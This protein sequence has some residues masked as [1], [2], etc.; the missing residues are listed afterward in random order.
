LFLAV[1][2]RVNDRIEPTLREAATSHPD[3]PLAEPRLT[4]RQAAR[5]TPC[6]VVVTSTR[7]TVGVRGWPT[8]AVVVSRTSR[9]EDD[10]L[11]RLAGQLEGDEAM[12]R[13]SA[14]SMRRE[15]DVQALTEST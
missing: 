11:A 12:D 8:S 15:R 1:L 4:R 9:L 10:S 14:D 3:D 2:G 6:P 13:P 7:P 5:A